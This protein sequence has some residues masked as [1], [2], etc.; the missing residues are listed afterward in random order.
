IE[1]VISEVLPQHKAEEV[2]RL[3]KDGKIVAFVGDGI[4]DAPALS[5]ADIGIAMGN[6][7]D[8]AVESGDVVLVNSDPV[9]TVAAIQLGRK[10]ISKIK[11]NLFWAFAYNISLIPLAAGILYPVWKITFKPEIAGFAMALSS[12]TVVSLSLLLKT[13]TPPVLGEKRVHV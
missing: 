11:W 2:K 3:Q 7:T 10:L 6:G 8:I 1:S 4:N 5:Q 13:Y 9:Y 12:V